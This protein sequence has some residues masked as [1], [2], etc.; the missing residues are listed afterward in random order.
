MYALGGILLAFASV[1]IEVISFS[2][3][4]SR[5]ILSTAATVAA[6]FLIDRALTHVPQ[7]HEAAAGL[8]GVGVV[9]TVLSGA[10]GWGMRRQSVG[11]RFA[12]ILVTALVV[13]AVGLISELACDQ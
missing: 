6:L 12:A 10:I 11:L 9:C 7:C 4:W 2:G 1:S 5:V 13:G 8:V 3:W